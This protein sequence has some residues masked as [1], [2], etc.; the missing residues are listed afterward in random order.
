MPFGAVLLLLLVHTVKIVYIR[1]MFL[2]SVEVL[3]CCRS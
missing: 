1:Y 2:L 3:L